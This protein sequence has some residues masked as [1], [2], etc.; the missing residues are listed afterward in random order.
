MNKYIGVKIINAKPMTVSE[1]IT[2]TKRKLHYSGSD[3]NG[4]HVV[5]EDGYF[6]WSPK[7]VFELAYRRIDDMTFG[8][9]IEALK[10]GYK[11]ARSGWN[12]K[13]MWLE[14]QVPDEHSKM[15]LPYIYLNY[16]KGEAHPTG[17][18]VPW[19]ASQTDVLSEDWMIID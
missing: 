17:A 10:K 6:S 8:L 4:Y 15:T 19:L 7:K 11:V 18:R 3:Q 9:A 13:D 14:L 2:S 5:Y 12:G 16:P 1:Y